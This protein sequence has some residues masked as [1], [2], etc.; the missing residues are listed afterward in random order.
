MYLLKNA[1]KN[2]IRS[3]GRNLLIGLIVLII[4]VSACISL[5][6]REAAENAKKDCLKNTEITGQIAVDRQ[7]LMEDMNQSGADRSEMKEKMSQMQSLSV[8][9][10]KKYAESD[11][12]KN[13]YYT[14]TT[15]LNGNNIDEVSTEETSTDSSTASSQSGPGGNDRKMENQGAFSLIGYSSEDAMTNFVNGTCKITDGSIFTENTS[16]NVC[17]ISDELATYNSLK[18]GS[19]IK[20]ESPTDDSATITLKIV[21]IY[22]NSSSTSGENGV[23]NRFNAGADP[24]NQIYTSYKALNFMVKNIDSIMTQTSGTYVFADLDSY[25]TFQKDVKKMGLDDTYTVT[26]QDVNNYEQSLI[27]LENLSKF[28]SY[29][30]IIVLIIGAVILAV[31][32]IF[33]IRERKYEIG[34]LT[35]IGMKKWKVCTQFVSEL[36]FVTIFSMVIGLGIGSAASVPISNQLLASQ[37]ENQQEQIENQENNFG[38]GNTQQSSDKTSNTQGKGGFMNQTVNYVSDISATVNITVMMQ[39]LAV[40]IILTILS[41]L[42]AVIFIVRYEPL[43]ILTNRS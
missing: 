10:L 11:A 32:N 16:E 19:S 28:A 41:S 40:G 20:L 29:F 35:A 12:V 5:S 37:I 7:S 13:F 42:T 1:W 26:S 38:R 8:S 39:L 25:E 2:V 23:M 6:I 43:K 36:F 15:S 34:V 14:M 21:G 9:Q 27:P 4:S 24:A 17:I 33:N 22:H 18:V 30:F 31:I 3:K